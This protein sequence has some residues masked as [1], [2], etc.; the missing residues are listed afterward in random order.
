VNTATIQARVSGSCAAGSS[1]RTINADGTVACEP[2]DGAN[3]FVQGGNAFGA[4]PGSVATLGTNDTNAL[5]LRAN[6]QRVMRYEPNSISPNVIGG[7]PANSVTA[8]V[9][10]A[11]IAGG[12]APAGV[13]PD[14]F[15]EA[16]NRVTDAYGTVSGGHANRAGDDTGN[17]TDRAFATVGGGYL[18]TASDYASTVAGGRGNTASGFSSTVTGGGSNTASG[19]LSAIGGGEFNTAGGISSVVVG[20]LRST[21]SGFASIVAGG[22]DN[23]ASGDYSFAAGN[24]ANANANGCFVWSDRSQPIEVRCDAANRFV[25]RSQNGVYFFSAGTSQANY[26]GVE[27]PPG[28]SAWVASSDRRLKEN[29][30]PVNTAEVLDRLVA[31]PITTWNLR[32][33]DPSIRH[34]GAMAQDFR[35]AFGLGESELGINTLD[36]DGVALA[37]IQGLN[38]KVEAQAREAAELRAQMAHEVAELRER[39][40]AEVAELRRTIASLMLALAHRGDDH[41]DGVRPGLLDVGRVLLR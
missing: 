6:G 9:R 14:F 22:S 21:A 7:S 15:D 39:H 5:E 8:G 28:A 10:G 38:A 19:F 18:N 41:V 29:L 35:A 36:A 37:A 13:D 3:A 17:V 40:A 27:L 16:P 20:G 30:R 11:T 26:S 24:R 34:M 33:Q 12:G 2:D 4:L 1:I 25:V 23:V 31:L 32:A